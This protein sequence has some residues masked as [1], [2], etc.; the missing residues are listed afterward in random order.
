MSLCLVRTRDVPVY[1]KLVLVKR[2]EK[3]TYKRKVEWQLRDLKVL[4]G[5]AADS[6]EMRFELEERHTWLAASLEEK[7]AFLKVVQTMC[8]RYN[9]GR[10]TKFLNMRPAEVLIGEAASARGQV[11]ICFKTR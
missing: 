8:E 3:D 1:V 6:A 2:T 4:D 10:K 11:K 7:D 9:V 5:L